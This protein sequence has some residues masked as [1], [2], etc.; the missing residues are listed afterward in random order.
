MSAENGDASVQRNVSEAFDNFIRRLNQVYT[1]GAAAAPSDFEPRLRYWRDS[2]GL[3]TEVHGQLQ[4]LRVWR[5]ASAHHDLE[6]WRR[7][8]PRSVEEAS[9]HLVSLDA[10]VHSLEL[11]N[12]QTRGR[13][14]FVNTPKEQNA[15]KPE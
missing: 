10:A 11:G 14:T 3:P 2:C 6:R 1:S 12:R 15:A 13:C 8:G 4:L 5:N 7:D 9:Q